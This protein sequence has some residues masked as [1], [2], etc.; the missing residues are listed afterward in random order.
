MGHLT[1]KP[2][3]DRHETAFKLELLR[4][5]SQIK[6]K[7]AFPPLDSGASS[8]PFSNDRLNPIA[9]DAFAQMLLKVIERMLNLVARRDAINERDVLTKRNR[10]E[11]KSKTQH[12]AA[13]VKPFHARSSSS[14]HVRLPHGAV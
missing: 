3:H 9:R 10:G 12:W 4:I 7:N 11:I 13:D 2:P 6:R 14:K 5:L 1:M 8:F